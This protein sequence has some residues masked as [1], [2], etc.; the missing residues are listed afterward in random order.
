MASANDEP[1]K[2]PTSPPTGAARPGPATSPPQRDRITGFSILF[3][4][5]CAALIISWKASEAVRPNV[6]AE[7]EPPTSE[8]LV[9]YPHQVEPLN[10]LRVARD[11]TER[12][13]LRRILATGVSPDGTVDLSQPSAGIRYD[14]DSAAGEGP[15]APRPAGTVRHARYCGR[16]S[17]HVKADG[18]AAEADQPRAVCRAA[19]GSPLP[20]PRCSL[21]QLWSLAKERKPDASGVAT[22]EYYRA[23]EGPAWRF[24]QAGLDFVIFGDCERELKGKEARP[25][26][27]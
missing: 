11:L 4:A 25:L 12:T 19:L 6:A 13:Q 24:S 26:G 2:E 7:P 18:I 10:A 15:E 21:Q 3:V 23:D 27:P 20:E 14:F 8:G 16:Q 22:I 1:A 5:F 17:V 9:G